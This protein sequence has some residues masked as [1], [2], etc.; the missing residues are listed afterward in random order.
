MVTKNNEKHITPDTFSLKF[1]AHL[2]V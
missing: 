1:K 2:K